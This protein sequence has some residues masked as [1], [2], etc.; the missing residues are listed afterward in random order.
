[1]INA[2]AVAALTAAVLAAP[3]SD[4]L[5]ASVAVVVQT[6][7]FGIRIGPAGPAYVPP[8]AY[9]PAP[10]YVPAPVYVPPRVV[11]APPPM[12]VPGPV[13]YPLP[14]AY[15]QV[16]P[17]RHGRHAHARPYRAIVPV[18]GYVDGRY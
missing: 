6:P 18:V 15:V 3:A 5:A 9:A 12:V 8:P 2:L 4:A 7:G 1:M 17:R 14:P 10:A 16:R 11:Y 13:I